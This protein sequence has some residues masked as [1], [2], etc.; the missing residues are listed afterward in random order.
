MVKAVVFDLGKVLVDF[1]YW[2]AARRVALQSRVSAAEIM[3][4]FGTSPLLVDYE[5][6]RLDRFQLF[7]EV[8]AV[9]GYTGPM[10][11]FAR[12]YSDI[13]VE[14]QPMVRLQAE[15]EQKGIPT[16]IFSNTNDL[17]VEHIPKS[18]P[19]YRQFD[20]HILS[21]QHGVMKPEPE[22]YQVVERVSGLSG[23]DLLYFDDRPENVA[24]GVARGWHGVVHES[25]SQSWAA[26]R[27]L[28]VVA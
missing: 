5:K 20:G 28:G 1:D 2:I 17:A 14:I 6:G 7:R 8:C 19:F 3:N 27:Q 15:L 12:A 23:A 25:P 4:L 21:Y 13:F 16:Y 9:T 22:L 10:E 26:A 18:F 11:D 24:A